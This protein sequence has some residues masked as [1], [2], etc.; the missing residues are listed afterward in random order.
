MAATANVVGD[1]PLVRVSGILYHN[2]WQAAG[3]VYGAGV[4]CLTC[5]VYHCAVPV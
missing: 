1:T 4:V 5:R 3:L 2:G